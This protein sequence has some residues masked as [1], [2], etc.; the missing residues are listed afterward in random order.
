MGES[1]A[2]GWSTRWWDVTIWG[3]ILLTVLIHAVLHGWTDEHTVA[4]VAMGAWVALNLF[5][6]H[7]HHSRRH[8]AAAESMSP[9]ATDQQATTSSTAGVHD[10]RRT[11]RLRGIAL[12]LLVVMVV[13]ILSTDNLMAPTTALGVWIA[14]AWIERQ[15]RKDPIQRRPPD[16]SLH[17]ATR[18]N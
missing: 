16:P 18:R 12:V 5:W 9:T 2:S 8:R 4:A 6:I 13:F 10:R 11:V 1:S 14:S 7:R 3:T 15:Q 17:D